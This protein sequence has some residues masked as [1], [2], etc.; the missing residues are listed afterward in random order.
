MK[1]LVT[2]KLADRNFFYHTYPITLLESV[3]EIMVVRDTEGIKSNK[4]TYYCPPVWTLKIPPLAFIYKFILM[5]YLSISKNP[6]FIYG[7]LLFPHASLAFL[8]GK[9]TNKK[10]G[11]SLIAGPVE[12]FSSGSP[13][14]DYSY[15]DPLPKLNLRAKIFAWILRSSDLVTVTGSYTKDFLTS[16]GINKEKIFI[17]YHTVDE[18]FKDED[19]E[20]EYDI[21]YVGRL[22]K[23]KHVS[24]I[25][26][27]VKIIK[28][29][30][31]NLRVAI[32]GDGNCKFELKSLSKKLGVDKNVDFVGYQKNVEDWY[33]KSKIFV[34]TSEREGFP[35]TVIESLK[36]GVP[37]ITSDCGDVCDLI[38]DGYNGFFIDNYYDYEAFADKIIEI[39]ENDKL[40]ERLS[41]NSLESIDNINPDNLSI[42]WKDIFS[43]L[44][45]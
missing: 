31:S 15:C 40:L 44:S 34:L 39:L 19:T 41:D 26:K 45:K 29:R 3:E 4:I 25:I 28:K 6:S 24:T 18:R 10:V 5:M 37:V 8:V 1:I 22:G 12:L 42:V 14:D 7:Y 43:F 2:G 23:V 17:L 13:I 20:K 32:V 16:I 33:N 36:C 21:V 30:I 9:L 35:Y 27:S 11:I 38:E